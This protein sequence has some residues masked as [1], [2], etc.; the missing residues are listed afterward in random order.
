MREAFKKEMELEAAHHDFTYDK[1]IKTPKKDDGV[2]FDYIGVEDDMLHSTEYE[3]RASV[4]GGGKYI[5]TD[6]HQC[7]D[8]LPVVN[9]HKYTIYGAGKAWVKLSGDSNEKF[10]TRTQVKNGGKTVI[11]PHNDKKKMAD[12][13]LLRQ[14][15]CEIEAIR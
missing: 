10:R 13:E 14:I 12:C 5:K 6:E 11:V 4:Y 2:V 9:G 7:D 1:G 8:G 15:R 3:D